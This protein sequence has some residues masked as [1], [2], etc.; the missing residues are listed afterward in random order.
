MRDPR[1][2]PGV[3][4]KL[5]AAWEAAPDLRLGQLVCV[6]A[7]DAGFGDAFHIEDDSLAKAAEAQARRWRGEG[8]T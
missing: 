6:L 4:E 3:L 1:R 2:I 7:L 8:G 5:R